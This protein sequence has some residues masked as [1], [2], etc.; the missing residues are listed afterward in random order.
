LHVADRHGLR[1]TNINVEIK[2]LQQSCCQTCLFEDMLNSYCAVVPVIFHSLYAFTD[3]FR[4]IFLLWSMLSSYL[5]S[6]WRKRWQQISL[7]IEGAL[8]ALHWRFSLI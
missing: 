4:T 1:K 6:L 8:F 7:I 3:I 2:L 5:L